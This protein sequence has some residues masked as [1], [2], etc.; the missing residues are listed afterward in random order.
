MPKQFPLEVRDRL[1]EVA[2]HRI[3][4]DVAPASKR[5]LQYTNVWMASGTTVIP[6]SEPTQYGVPPKSYE[7]ADPAKGFNPRT[8]S[9][10]GRLLV[11]EFRCLK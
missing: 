7:S 5:P 8:H 9:I 4:V 10:Y 2:P 6:I 11:T 1:R 3:D